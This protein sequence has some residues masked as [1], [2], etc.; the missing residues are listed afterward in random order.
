MSIVDP[1]LRRF[2]T[3]FNSLTLNLRVRYSH[4][5]IRTL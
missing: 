3:D 1:T 4:E 2:G 5:T